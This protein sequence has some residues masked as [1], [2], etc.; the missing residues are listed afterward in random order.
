MK[1]SVEGV[2]GISENSVKV[3]FATIKELFN[4]LHDWFKGIYFVITSLASMSFL[5]K[6]LGLIFGSIFC[7]GIIVVLYFPIKS[8]LNNRKQEKL[9]TL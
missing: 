2:D 4:I 1:K 3:L 7:I 6:Y 9:P 8:E 5:F